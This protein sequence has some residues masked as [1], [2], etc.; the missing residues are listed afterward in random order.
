MQ[1]YRLSVGYWSHC[2]Q[3][4]EILKAEGFARIRF[5]QRRSLFNAFVYEFTRENLS[6]VSKL[7]CG[8]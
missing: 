1:K 4:K 6:L 8:R 7:A 2:A 3:V 5:S